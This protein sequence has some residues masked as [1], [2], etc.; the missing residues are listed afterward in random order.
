MN[1]IKNGERFSKMGEA[2]YNGEKIIIPNVVSPAFKQGELLMVIYQ[3][4]VDNKPTIFTHGF[5]SVWER[6]VS[7]RIRQVIWE[8]VERYGNSSKLLKGVPLA[9]LPDNKTWV[10]QSEFS[11]YGIL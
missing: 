5:N 9:V 8:F 3:T 10:F 11:P 7:D 4:L 2:Y 6:E 1:H